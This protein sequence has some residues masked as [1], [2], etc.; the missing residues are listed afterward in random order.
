VV[1]RTVVLSPRPAAGDAEFPAQLGDQLGVPPGC[2]V[3]QVEPVL[4]V[5]GIG[6]SLVE[7]GR[8]R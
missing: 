6:E 5:S 2:G 4:G 7:F 1:R 3:E 8:A